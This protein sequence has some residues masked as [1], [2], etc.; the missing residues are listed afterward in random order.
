MKETIKVLALNTMS[1][2]DILYN[3]GCDMSEEDRQRFESAISAL[4]VE[5][6]R[7]YTIL[8]GE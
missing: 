1:L 3:Y 5:Y 7:L 4:N 8:Y 2:E 6:N